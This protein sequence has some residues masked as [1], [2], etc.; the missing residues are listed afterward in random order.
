VQLLDGAVLHAHFADLGAHR[1]RDALRLQPPDEGG[2]LRRPLVVGALLLRQ[3]GL[4]QVHQRGGVHVDVVEAGADLLGD[5]LLHLAHLAL[6]V[7]LVLLVIDLAVVALNEEREGVA[8]PQGGGD[9]HR[10]VLRRALI[11]VGDLGAGDLQD[12]GPGLASP[13]GAKDRAGGVVGHHPHVDRRHGEPADVAPAARLIE[14]VDRGGAGPGGLTQLPE[15]PAGRLPLVAR[16][17]HGALGEL[18]GGGG[19]ERGGVPHGDAAGRERHGPAVEIH[20]PPGH[21]SHAS[22]SSPRRAGSATG[23]KR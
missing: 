17:E 21:I 11:G 9:Q 18:V 19:A 23:R 10:D 1:D 20:Q 13:G 22:S 6:G 16:A 3:G 14:R 15:Q 12:D 5:Q 2:D 7:G 4:L 8:L